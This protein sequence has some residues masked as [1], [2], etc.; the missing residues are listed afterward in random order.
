VRKNKKLPI[1]ER[2]NL[3]QPSDW[4][5]AFEVEA[6]KRGLSLSEFMGIAGSKMLP[7]EQRARLSRRIRAG[8]KLVVAD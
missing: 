3:T 2:K 5:Q 4:W 7:K 6:D 8:R 1:S